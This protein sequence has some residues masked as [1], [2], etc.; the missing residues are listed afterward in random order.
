MKKLF[1]F[2]LVLCYGIGVSAGDIKAIVNDVPIS[3]YDVI[4]R[5]KLIRLQQPST[6]TYLSSDE[7]NKMALET[8]VDE[9]VKSQEAQKQGFNISQKDIDEAINRLENQNNMNAGDM[10]KALQQNNIPFDILKK[11][12]ETDLL[13]LQVL[14][15]NKSMISPVSNKEINSE[16]NKIKQQLKKP[17]YLLAEIV[18]SSEK[19]AQKILKDIQSGQVFSQIAA[20]KSLA[21]SAKNDGLIGWVSDTHYPADI[22]KRI[23]K[24]APNEMLKPMPYKNGWIIILLLDKKAPIKDGK[25]TIWDLAQLAVSRNKTVSFI[26]HIFKTT[27]CESF[28]QQAE[29]YA[30]KGSDRRGLVNPDQLPP[31][32]K[33][34]LSQKKSG[35]PIGPIG[36][37]EGDLFFMKCGEKN[38]SVLPPDEQIKSMLEMQKM[39]ELS[40]K[41]LRKVKHYAVIEY[42]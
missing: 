32:L 34:M 26:P 22:M 11:Q 2:C 40:N 35:T 18:V 33:H 24:M 10:I 27:D 38:Q 23:S 31:E 6:T 9:Q 25:I 36:T 39:E 3:N 16:K 13:W 5:A 8:L 37:E 29:K 7:L 14:S 4:E 1:I 19:E 12:I 30:L 20:K 15:K 41:I 17:S 28:Q 42:K 21:N